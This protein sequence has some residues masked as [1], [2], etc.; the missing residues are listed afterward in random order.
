MFRSELLLIKLPSH[1]H[2]SQIIDVDNS[3]PQIKKE[4]EKL[5]KI[6]Y[7]RDFLRKLEPLMHV[8]T[9]KLGG[10]FK[11]AEDVGMAY[12]SFVIQVRLM[13]I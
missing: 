2:L 12:D 10:E 8:L 3:C 5:R 13:R 9:E 4:D 11:T 6:P 7:V 1:Q